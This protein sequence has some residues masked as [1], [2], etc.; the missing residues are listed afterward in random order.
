MSCK[1]K[2]TAFG[3]SKTV[4]VSDFVD[5]ALVPEEGLETAADL[6]S[7][8]EAIAGSLGALVERLASR[9]LLD[10]RDVVE[11]AGSY[12]EKAELILGKDTQD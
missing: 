2:T 3:R 10:A 5:D 11:V 7:A 6:N 12:A 8:V 4:S 9:G 1:I